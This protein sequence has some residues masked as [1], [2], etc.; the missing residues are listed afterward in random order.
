MIDRDTLADEGMPEGPMSIMRR[1]GDR[2]LWWC[3]GCDRVHEAD[4]GPDGWTLAGGLENPT[5]HPSVLVTYNGPDAGQLRDD[6]RRAP[7][8][9]CHTFIVHGHIQYLSDC[10][11]ELAEQTVPMGPLPAHLAE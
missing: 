8:A 4:I 2:V 10:T 9:V 11:H 1:R 3:P 5:L 7:A 6:N